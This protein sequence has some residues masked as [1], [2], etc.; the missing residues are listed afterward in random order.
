MLISGMH[1]NGSEGP[2]LNTL[3]NL[4]HLENVKEKEYKIATIASKNKV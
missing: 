4:A 3:L 2:F 1:R